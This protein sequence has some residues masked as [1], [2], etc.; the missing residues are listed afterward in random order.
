MVNE[1]NVLNILN[2]QSMYDYFKKHNINKNGLYALFSVD[3]P[4]I[5]TLPSSEG[6]GKIIPLNR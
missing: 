5:S 6:L 1:K 4:P 3:S 2:G